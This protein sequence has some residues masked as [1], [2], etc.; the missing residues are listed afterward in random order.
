MLVP[1]KHPTRPHNWLPTRVFEFFGNVALVSL[2]FFHPSLYVWTVCLRYS[3][4]SVLGNG[5]PF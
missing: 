5:P 3:G 1:R 2:H 4:E